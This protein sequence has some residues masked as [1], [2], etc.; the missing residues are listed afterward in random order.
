MQRLESTWGKRL[1]ALSIFCLVVGGWFIHVRQRQATETLPAGQGAE[2][3]CALWFV[4]SSSIHRWNSLQRDMAPWNAHNR[5]INSA[6][7]EQILPRFAHIDR[8]MPRPAA[9]ILYAGENDIA[10]GRPVRT[11]VHELATFLDL[12]SQL[13]GD[14][15]V[16]VLSSKPSPGRWHFFGDQKLLNAAVT[17]LLPQMANAHYGDITT[18]LLKGGTLGDNYGAD[19]VHMNAA[20]Y[21]IL[22]TVVRKRLGEILPEQTIGRCTARP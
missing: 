14:V 3:A 19:G 18:P 12:R 9:I 1:L 10:S 22:A 11:I 8:S 6:T 20:G 15:P 16:L 4:G 5:G 7:F 13:L 17:R 21:H 2:G